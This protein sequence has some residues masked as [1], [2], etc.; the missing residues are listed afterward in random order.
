MS[1]IGKL[2]NDAIDK[3]QEL[4]SE[5]KEAGD[6][7]IDVIQEQTPAVMESAR[8]KREEMANATRENIPVLIAEAKAAADRAMETRK[9]VAE[10]VMDATSQIADKSVELTKEMGDRAAEA[11]KATVERI[12]K[13]DSAEEAAVEE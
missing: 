5:M 6:K 8:A 3:A 10:H 9:E 1:E 12:A 13:K 2:I 4:A 11:A 7:V